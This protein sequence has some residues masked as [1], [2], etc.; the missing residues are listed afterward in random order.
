MTIKETMRATQ[1][2]ESMLYSQILDRCRRL[3]ILWKMG[4]W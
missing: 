3:V 4:W 1:R 2:V